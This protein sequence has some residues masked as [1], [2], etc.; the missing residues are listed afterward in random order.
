MKHKQ[1]FFYFLHFIIFTYNTIKAL[2]SPN[3]IISDISNNFLQNYSSSISITIKELLF[4]NETQIF[5]KYSYFLATSKSG[6]ISIISDNNETLFSFDFKKKM[7]E[8]N[9][10]QTNI[11]NE[12]K[13]VLALE[14]K[15]FIV[16]NNFES[17]NFEEFTTPI[18]ELV[19]MTPFSLL[20]MPDYYFLSDKKYSIIKIVN[21]N[22]NNNYIIDL[23]LVVFVDY[24]LICLK[25]KEQ[26]WNTTI[27][28][29]Y[30]LG[31]NEEYKIRNKNIKI[32][33]LMLIYENNE[34]LEK[35]VKNNFGNNNDILFIHGY[36][37][38]K[39]KYIKI[40]DFNTFNHLV[41]NNTI[42]NI[43]EQNSNVGSL[44]YKT[45]IPEKKYYMNLLIYL[46]IITLIIILILLILNNFK[47]EQFFPI[48]KLYENINNKNI[49]SEINKD[50]K[51]NNDNT[52]VLSNDL[53]N[54]D[55]NNNIDKDDIDELKIKKPYNVIFKNI[56][57]S[58]TLT[59][60]MNNTD[61]KER[62]K[63]SDMEKSIKILEIDINNNINNNINEENININNIESQRTNIFKTIKSHLNKVKIKSSSSSKNI[64]GYKKM[65]KFL[66][67]KTPT[68]YDINIK[69]IAPRQKSKFNNNNEQ[70]KKD[71][72]NN[73]NYYFDADRKIYNIS[74]E[75]KSKTEKNS[76]PT[77][78]TRLE[79]DFVD[80]TL[81]KK[82]KIGNN[83]GI[84]LKA[85]HIIDEEIYAIKIKKLS[86]PNDEQIVINEA[87]NMTK[88]HSKHIVEYITCWFDKS[89]GKF[90][91]LFRDENNDDDNL[92]D[93]TKKDDEKYSSSLKNNKKIF[94]EDGINYKNQI[95][96]EQKK[97]DYVTQLYEKRFF[98]DDEY[99]NNKKKV[100][101]FDKKFYPK[102][103]TNE[104]N[105]QKIKL[106]ESIINN[107][108]DDSLIKRN[109][110]KKDVPNLNMYFFIQMEFIQGLTLSE[111]L[112]N[113]S[114][115]GIN[116]KILYTFTYQI[117]KSLSRIHENKIVHRDINPDNIFI[118]NENSI[119]IG[120]FSSAKEI[121]SSKYKKK[122]YKTNEFQMSLSTGKLND[123]EE[124][125]SNDEKDL[126][127]ENW[128]SSIYW[129][130]EQEQGSSANQKS[131]IY[132]V[133]LVL[134]IMCECLGSEKERKKSI[135]RLKTKNVISEKVK[136]LFN[137]QYKLILKMID[138]EPEN[139]PNCKQLLDS[140]EMKEWKNMIDE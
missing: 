29:V 30:F 33:E 42:N 36:D 85:K 135:I 121:E 10:E 12:D 86:N 74:D 56:Q 112:N 101:C 88:I 70:N 137:L 91:Y 76:Q 134:Y 103:N 131:D 45:N 77:S 84:I 138:Y 49:N 125:E 34:I 124:N 119:K 60:D 83:I 95:S 132:S 7:Y 100:I 16:K 41:Q 109:I 116:N 62:K 80:V 68:N 40:Y 32:E 24:T 51:I 104:E 130:P 15:L 97:N 53:N 120:D 50:D 79:K 123:Q 127:K 73:D 58:F 111:Y 61:S 78:L 94:K 48:S 129:S 82:R 106:N 89:L 21:N 37:K 23:N 71:D 105:K 47:F 133:G 90:E 26:V 25:D 18:S 55:K 67:N 72:E 140:D 35:K 69:E 108:N 14:G 75:M 27:T 64:K 102:K 118:D 126:D 13:A 96:Q 6:I 107:Y 110:S 81:F 66:H 44:E 114:K 11:I 2:Q 31:K 87:K 65:K 122:I 19:D 28:N 20:F 136:N 117:I 43:E 52:P 139:R 128:E 5:S 115:L 3:Y 46:S 92:S 8:T 99:I 22:N 9:I 4:P 57:N 93:S 113:H 17:Q 1:L 98:S 38:E 59:D 39:K 54:N 63:T